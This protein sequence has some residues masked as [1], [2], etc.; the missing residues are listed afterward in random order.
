LN[1][2]PFQAFFSELL[3]RAAQ[4]G[5]D[6][7][8][9]VFVGKSRTGRGR[10]HGVSHVGHRKLDDADT[11]AHFGLMASPVRFRFDDGQLLAGI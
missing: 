4:M 10:P 8:A 5:R 2:E 9:S 7:L 3:S 11:K 6:F 1:G